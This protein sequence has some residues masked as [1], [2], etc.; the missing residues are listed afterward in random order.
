MGIAAAINALK[1]K[2]D[3]AEGDWNND[4]MHPS[5]FD[6]QLFRLGLEQPE[7]RAPYLAMPPEDWD[8]VLLDLKKQK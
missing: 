6:V 5:V 2:R 8:G 1:P 4:Y 3:Q 7:D